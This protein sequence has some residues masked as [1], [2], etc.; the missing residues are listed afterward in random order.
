[1]SISTTFYSLIETLFYGV[2]V[3]TR[4]TV[5]FIPFPYAV[6]QKTLSHFML[7]SLYPIAIIHYYI[8]TRNVAW[9]YDLQFYSD[10]WENLL[11]HIAMRMSTQPVLFGY[12]RRKIGMIKCCYPLG[13]RLDKWKQFMREIWSQYGWRTIFTLRS[14][15]RFNKMWEKNWI[16]LRALGL[17]T[18]TQNFLERF[19]CEKVKYSCCKF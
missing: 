13:L 14:N 17:M 10:I 11:W 18:C 7:R 6:T 5:L 16:C 12:A 2:L 8:V 15:S 3:W 1:M 19:Q 9:L 4:M